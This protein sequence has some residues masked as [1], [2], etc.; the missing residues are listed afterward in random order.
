MLKAKILLI[1]VLLMPFV[2]TAQISLVKDFQCSFT[3]RNFI[4]FNNQ[5][6]FNGTAGNCYN[7][8]MR[9]DGTA[10]G[11]ALVSGD[12]FD[13]GATRRAVV[14]GHLYFGTGNGNLKRINGTTGLVELV[15]SGFASI[16]H[17]M[18]E[19]NGL[20]LFTDNGA[21]LWRSDGTEAGTYA[22]K[23]DLTSI[24]QVVSD[25]STAYFRGGDDNLYKTDGTAAGT[26]VILNTGGYG[27]QG[28]TIWNGALYF[29]EASSLVT[30]YSGGNF[31]RL[32]TPVMSNTFG[33]TTRFIPT[34]NALYFFG[35]AVNAAPLNQLWK[36]DGTVAGTGL[37]TTMSASVPQYFSQYQLA[38]EGYQNILYFPAG[39][40]TYGTELWRSDGTAGGTFR[41]ADIEPGAGSSFPTGL[42]VINGVC[43]FMATNTDYGSELWKSDGSVAGTQLV[44][45][46]FPGPNSGASIPNINTSDYSG[47]NR[48]SMIYNGQ[49]YFAGVANTT[50]GTQLYAT[51]ASGG[52]RFRY[53]CFIFRAGLSISRLCW[54]GPL[55]ARKITKVFPS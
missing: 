42:G 10:N 47:A 23:S 17:D 16:P 6:Y 14:G 5:L 33:N 41:L 9:T 7:G 19:V 52:G 50:T 32:Y 26:S 35:A 27:V 44:Q 40:G 53:D 54:P 18:V 25:G 38:P 3:P 4:R 31:T 37:V 29:L 55:P 48:Y 15:K 46:L 39:D 49:Y 1:L 36:T 8:I 51:T 43:Y 11:S 2:S 28:L 34:A 13:A 30:K 22:I 21:G 20:L 24:G 45:D 12:Q